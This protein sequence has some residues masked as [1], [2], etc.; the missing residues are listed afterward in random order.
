MDGYFHFELETV[1][2]AFN[3]WTELIGKRCEKSHQKL[4]NSK[5]LL[6]EK[7]TS[8]LKDIVH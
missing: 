5:I 8:Q 2:S 4:R 1:A 6:R 7:I 3:L